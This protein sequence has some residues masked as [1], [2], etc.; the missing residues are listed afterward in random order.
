MTTNEQNTKTVQSIRLPILE[1][2]RDRSR[3]LSQQQS[4]TLAQYNSYLN[5]A[6]LTTFLDWFKDWIPED[7]KYHVE[8][9]E[10]LASQWEFVHGTVIQ[11]AETRIVIIPCDDL[12]SETFEIP[13]EWI[14]IPHWNCDYYLPIEVSLGGEDDE[15]WIEIFG[16]TTHR[17]IKA[18]R[19][20]DANARTYG[21]DRK[22]LIEN[23][24]VMLRTME[25]NVK[26]EV[27]ALPTLVTAEAKKYIE[28]LGK[29]SIYSPRLHLPFEKWGAL[30]ENETYRQ[31]L[32]NLRMGKFVAEAVEEATP[33]KKAIDLRNWLKNIAHEI[34]QP[35]EFFLGQFEAVRSIPPT[36]NSSQKQIA[37]ILSLLHPNRS[38]RVRRQAAGVLGEIGHGNPEV[39]QA[40]IEV[41]QTSQDEETRWTASLSLRKIDPDNPSA[42]IEKTRKIDLG[43]RLGNCQIRLTIGIM[44]I[45]DNKL[46]V[47]TKVEPFGKE[48]TLPP[49]LQLSILSESGETIPRL[50]RTAEADLNGLGK[51][52]ELKLRFSRPIG[53]YFSAKV[54]WKESSIIEDFMV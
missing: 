43:I 27:P 7:F 45:A 31:Q 2:D 50:V 21:F 23:M 10:S 3:T 32:F 13:Q 17:Q 18:N 20:Y 28:E 42:G 54:S 44:P 36:K 1:R 9:S 8:N 30:L 22:D 11:L 19:K 26:V 38:E 4:N 6:C 52:Q 49:D 51:N 33:I 5:N 25:L 24:E 48:K 37:D 47:Y 40:L 46:R 39:I 34:W 35:S 15:C 53:S 12:E 16:L 41:L 29:R 14:D